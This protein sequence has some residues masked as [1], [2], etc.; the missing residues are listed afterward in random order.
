M[1]GLAAPVTNASC[2]AVWQPGERPE[3]NVPV[4]RGPNSQDLEGDNLLFPCF[5]ESKKNKKTKKQKNWAG[6]AIKEFDKVCSGQKP[7]QG[8]RSGVLAMTKRG[9]VLSLRGV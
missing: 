3:A 6:W 5:R 9:G 1:V 4:R 7:E 2:S 8:A